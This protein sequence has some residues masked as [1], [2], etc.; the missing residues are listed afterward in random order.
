MATIIVDDYDAAIAFFVDKLGFEPVEDAP[1]RTSDG[2]SKRWIIVRR[3]P[4]GETGV[5]L[6]RAA[7]DEQ[8]AAVGNQTAGRVA[9]FLR[10]DDFDSVYQQLTAADVRF[11]GS[12]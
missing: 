2:R 6:A 12:A 3:P 10:V 1:T 8:R 7:D 5:L 11:L 4:G 9:Y